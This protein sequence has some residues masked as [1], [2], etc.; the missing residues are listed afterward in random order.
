[1]SCI[2]YDYAAICWATVS[3]EYQRVPRTDAKRPNDAPRIA[4][5]RPLTSAGRIRNPDGEADD[6]LRAD[7]WCDTCCRSESLS[8]SVRKRWFSISSS[9]RWRRPERS[10]LHNV[11]A[12]DKKSQRYVRRAANLSNRDACIRFTEKE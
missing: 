2:R 4:W 10:G 9:F 12:N 7:F 5:L 3:A 6:L 8:S 1:M 11:C